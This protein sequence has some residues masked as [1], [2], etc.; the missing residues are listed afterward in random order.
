[1]RLR[2][3]VVIAIGL[4]A[5]VVAALYAAYRLIDPLPPRRFAIAV[6]FAGTPYD[7]FARQYAAILARHGV[8]LDPQYG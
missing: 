7:N 6:G 2:L 3:P 1:M 4:V 5:T 8:E